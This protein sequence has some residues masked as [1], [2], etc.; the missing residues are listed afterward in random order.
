M[1]KGNLGQKNESNNR[2]LFESVVEKAHSD[3]ATLVM[4]N[5]L[6]RFTQFSTAIQVFVPEEECTSPE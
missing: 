3:F 6:P 2:S 5:Y 1:P 4:K